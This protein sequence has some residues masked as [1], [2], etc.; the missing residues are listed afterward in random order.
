MAGKYVLG[1]VVPAGVL[2]A[3]AVVGGIAPARQARADDDTA[4]VTATVVVSTGITITGVTPASFTLTGVPGQ[5]VNTEG[6]GGVVATIYTNSATGYTLTVGPASAIDDVLTPTP[7]T[8]NT[9][10]IT[11]L[12]VKAGLAPAV[13]TATYQPL[14]LFAQ[15]PLLVYTGPG[16]SATAG[17]AV[18][19]DFQITIPVVAPGTYVATLNYV[20]T[21]TP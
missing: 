3:V 16:A 14:T 5:V 18:R 12:N 17:D 19:T 9:I 1:R 2:A 4:S 20:A 10:P 21:T 8:P 13:P 6:V 15:P 11:A 7:T